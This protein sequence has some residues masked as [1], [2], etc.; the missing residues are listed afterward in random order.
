MFWGE[1]CR[2]FLAC[3]RCIEEADQHKEV[4]KRGGYIIKKYEDVAVDAR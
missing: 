2:Y 4:C 3:E 1:Y